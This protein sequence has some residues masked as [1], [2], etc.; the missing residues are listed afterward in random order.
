MPM[1]G[2]KVLLTLPEPAREQHAVA[3]KRLEKFGSEPAQEL[4]EPDEILV[5]EGQRI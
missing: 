3:M 1:T 2:F 4:I 5:G